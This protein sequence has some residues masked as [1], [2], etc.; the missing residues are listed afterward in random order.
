MQPRSWA[1][2]LGDA[3]AHLKDPRQHVATGFPTIDSCLP[4]GLAG[5]RGLRPGHVALLIGRTEVG[6]SALAGQMLVNAVNSGHP[7]AYASLEMTREEVVIRCLSSQLDWDIDRVSEALV[8][9]DSVDP[10]FIAASKALMGL[11]VE[12][13]PA[14]TFDDLSKWVNSY[15]QELG[16][17]PRLVAV[18]Q[19][20]LMKRP[21]FQAGGEGGRIQQLAEDA[22]AWAKDT[23]V[24]LLL[25]HQVGKGAEVDDWGN[26]AKNH[27]DRPLTMEDSH[28]GG[29]MWADFVLGVYRP[30]RNPTLTADKLAVWDRV[31]VLQLLKNRHGPSCYSGAVLKWNRPSMRIEEL[32]PMTDFMEKQAALSYL[33]GAQDQKAPVVRTKA[34]LNGHRQPLF[35]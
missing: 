19:L 29:E 4:R 33:Q 34:T 35:P 32:E 13:R 17:R 5:D 6:K 14:P 23:Q 2:L 9:S 28:F 27:G 30:E 26:K 12:D 25:L 10:A 1:S 8:G 11:S 3:Q 15:G 21:K 31:M 18:D 22:K 7:S 16:H 24:G 20:M